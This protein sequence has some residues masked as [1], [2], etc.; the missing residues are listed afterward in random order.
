MIN[1]GHLRVEQTID[2]LRDHFYWPGMLPMENIDTYQTCQTLWDDG[3]DI[4]ILVLQHCQKKHLAHNIDATY[5]MELVHMDYL[6]VKA[7]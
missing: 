1:L 4:K 3:K 5:L 7:M 6:T 2:L